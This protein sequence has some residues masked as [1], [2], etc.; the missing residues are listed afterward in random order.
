MGNMNGDWG[1][2]RDDFCHSFSPL[3]LTPT[4]WSEILAFEQLEKETLGATWARFS[5]LLTISPGMPY[6]MK[7]P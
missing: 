5:H 3:S 4:P 1:K 6:P 2:L 7:F